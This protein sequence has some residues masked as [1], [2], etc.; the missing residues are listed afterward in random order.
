[1]I[2]LE[3]RGTR[4]SYWLS[5]RDYPCQGVAAEHNRLCLLTDEE[6]DCLFTNKVIDGPV[7]NDLQPSERD[8][9]SLVRIRP[10]RVNVEELII[11]LPSNDQLPRQYTEIVTP[12]HLTDRRTWR[13]RDQWFEQFRIPL[14]RLTNRIS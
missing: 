7:R 13:V 8:C 5:E 1:M 11:I 2:S 14:L 6:A 3:V 4:G 12:Y 9:R 10:N